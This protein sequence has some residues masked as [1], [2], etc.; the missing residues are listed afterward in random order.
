[1]KSDKYEEYLYVLDYSISAIYEIILD[2]EDEDAE[3]EDILKRR[4]LNIDECSW[5]FSNNRITN[6]LTLEAN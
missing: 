2:E 4:N 5:M 1:M 3:I 6:I